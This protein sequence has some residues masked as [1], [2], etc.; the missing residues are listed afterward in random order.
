MGTHGRRGFSHLLV[1]SVAEQLMR[2]AP[3]PVLT[4]G[5]G[6]AA[7]FSPVAPESA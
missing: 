5:R 2:H 7:T 3:C 4:V 6:C 1:G